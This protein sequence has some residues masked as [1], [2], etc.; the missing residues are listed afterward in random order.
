MNLTQLEE[1]KIEAFYRVEFQFAEYPLLR[2]GPLE[3]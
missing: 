2:D 3:K 1:I